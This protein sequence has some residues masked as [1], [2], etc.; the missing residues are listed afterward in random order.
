MFLCGLEE[1]L[2][3]H[4]GRGFDS[5]DPA[6]ADGVGNLEEE[7]RLCYVGLTRARERLTLTRAV[8]RVRRGKPMP[9]TPSRFLEDIP[10]DLL[11]VI[12]LGGPQPESPR[13]VQ[14]QKAKSFFASMSEMLGEAE[15]G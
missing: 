11:D 1:G 7:R 15:E 14:D 12:D 9:R 10:P 8:Q 4:S 2:L 3:P 5:A 13:A 6:A